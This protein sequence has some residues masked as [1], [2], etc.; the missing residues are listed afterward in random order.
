MKDNVKI[1]KTRSIA[2]FEPIKDLI[3]VWPKRIELS[4]NFDFVNSLQLPYF[5]DLLDIAVRCTNVQIVINTPF[6]KNRIIAKI[7]ENNIILSNIKFT[8]IFTDSIWLGDF[9][10]FYIEKNGKL[11]IVDFRCWP[12]LYRPIE[13]WFPTIFGKKNKI[14]C[15]FSANFFLTV[16]G[17]NYATNGAGIGILSSQVFEVNPHLR[18]QKIIDYLKYFL[19]LNKVI[20]LNRE[21][22]RTTG[23]IDMFAKIINENTILLGK[24]K[25]KNDEN[26][27]IMEENAKVLENN[28]FNLIR[29]PIVRNS[30]SI[31]NS[32]LSYANSF[33]LNGLKKKVVIIPRYNI[34]EDKDAML[35]Y[36]NSM[37]DYEIIGLNSNGVIKGFGG[38]HCILKSIPII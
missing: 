13:N 27:K 14:K 5:I 8:T 1:S 18:K 22:G 20:I 35:I 24:Y 37:P 7:K 17:G 31:G 19:G 32:S 23:H 21:L 33:I 11:E 26:Y 6:S 12:R 38:V 15:N 34:P 28:G 9:G 36:K 10:P 30:S 25:D 4:Y 3:L 2:E 29:I 16:Q